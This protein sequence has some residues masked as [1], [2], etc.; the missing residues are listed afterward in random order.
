LGGDSSTSRAINAILQKELSNKSQ[1]LNKID[2]DDDTHSYRNYQHYELEDLL[3]SPLCLIPTG[4]TNMIA[5]SI[6]G[7]TNI[8]TP[9][10]YLFYGI[11]LK[12]I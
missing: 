8:F 10:M 9:L 12:K 6:Y 3:T 11:C 1:N 2:E 7:I 5:N 4:S